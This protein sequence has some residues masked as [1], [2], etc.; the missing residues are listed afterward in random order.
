[1]YR[2]ILVPLDGSPRAEAILP[3]VENLA[4]RY[5]A[6]LILL[7]VDTAPPLLLER[8]EVVDLEAY[9][10]KRR[11]Q[12]QKTE[13]YLKGII[14]RWQAK[15]ITAVM[16]LEQGPVV[17]GIIVAAQQEQADLVA[18]ASHGAGGGKRAFYGSV[19][20]GV[21]QQIDRPLLLIRSRFVK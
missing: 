13:T 15:G 5:S 4:Q 6:R 3:H 1:M 11:Q 16:H 21:L 10:E 20:A 9:L 14:E 2:T 18:M 7:H 12:R 17:A 19:T 8:D